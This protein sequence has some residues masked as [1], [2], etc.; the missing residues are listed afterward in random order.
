M[1]IIKDEDVLSFSVPFKLWFSS[2]KEL[3]GF[4]RELLRSSE[5]RGETGAHLFNSG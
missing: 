5:A 2:T 4:I 1:G 3:L